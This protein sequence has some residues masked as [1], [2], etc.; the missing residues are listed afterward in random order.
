VLKRLL[1]ESLKPFRRVLSVVVVFQAIQ[2]VA[3]LLL[4][5]LNADIIDRASR[6][7]TPDT[8]AAWAW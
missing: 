6:V 7:V 2:A 3:G 8:S 1:S 4:P 5:T